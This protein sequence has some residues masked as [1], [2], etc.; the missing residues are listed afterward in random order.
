MINSED[1]IRIHEIVIDKYGGSKGIRDTNLLESALARPFQ[2]FN[3]K[4]L[5]FSPLDKAAAL[6]ESTLINHPFVDGN[7]RIGY[8]LMRLLLME[9]GF[10]ILATQDEKYEFVMSVA[11]GSIHY[12][13]IVE[14]LKSKIIIGS[15]T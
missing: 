15:I 4:D 2:T 3:K 11:N 13:R 7:K 1:A 6:M 8:V 9:H 12:D 14:W 5:Y 10:D